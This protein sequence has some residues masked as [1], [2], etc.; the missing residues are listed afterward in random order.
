M[1]DLF[2][3]TAKEGVNVVESVLLSKH[4]GVNHKD[5]INNT[6]KKHLA[7]IEKNFGRVCFENAPFMTKGGMQKRTIA[8]LSENQAIFISTLSKNTQ[9]VIE[10]KIKLVKSFQEARRLILSIPK[11]DD[12]L[13]LLGL[14][15]AQRKVLALK[16][17]NETLRPKADYTDKVLTSKYTYKT[18]QVAKELGFTAIGLNQ[19]LKDLGI[20]Y[21]VNGQWVL[22][23]KHMNK[24]YTDTETTTF[25]RTNGETGTSTLTVWTEKGR[26]FIHSLLNTPQNA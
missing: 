8:Y 23:A 14:Q 17:E 19:K 5:W 21:K 24:E 1:T 2:L 15:A 10:L 4:L 25:V 13:M 6:I 16:A 9:K 22:K 7:T 18:T 12:E 26:N 11:S 3:I 20:Q